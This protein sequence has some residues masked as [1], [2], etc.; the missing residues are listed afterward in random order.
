MIVP[1]YKEA[2][3]QRVLE[4]TRGIMERLKGVCRVRE[5]ARD[6]LRP[7]FKFNE[8]EM[9]GVPLRLEVGP[10]DLEAGQVTAAPR[11]GKETAPGKREKQTLP[12]AA[13]HESVPA[14]LEQ[15]QR[16]LY[17]AASKRLEENTRRVESYTEFKA[18]IEDPGGFLVAHWCGSAA[19]EAKVKEETKATIR[20]I[21]LSAPE[22][23]G[24][25]LI[26]GGQSGKRA[27]FARAY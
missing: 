3:R 10:R 21:P 7:G 11:I 16:N 6:G 1:I 22:E 5:D 20:C 18:L 25:C 4:G 26:C 24:A 27:W 23:P 9:K 2:E 17:D 15:I 12:I 19:C 14:L 8:W 13:L